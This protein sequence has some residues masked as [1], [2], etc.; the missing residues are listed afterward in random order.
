M[1]LAATPV[2]TAAEQQHDYDDNQEQF[3]GRPPL[4]Q[5]DIVGPQ[6]RRSTGRAMGA[7]S[8]F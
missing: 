2:S 8:I 6:A 1:T 7:K 3:H 5:G 4:T